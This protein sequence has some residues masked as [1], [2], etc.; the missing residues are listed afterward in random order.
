MKQLGILT[1]SWFRLQL[2]T[3]NQ[4]VIEAWWLSKW[5]KANKTND[6]ANELTVLLFFK[7]LKVDGKRIIFV[8]WSKKNELPFK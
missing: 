8:D 7:L 1:S 2:I 3:C 6:R 4:F 5:S